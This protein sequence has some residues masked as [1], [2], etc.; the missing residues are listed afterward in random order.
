[1]PMG[2]SGAFSENMLRADELTQ[3]RSVSVLTEIMFCVHPLNSPDSGS[4]PVW[5]WSWF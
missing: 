2:T 4:S 3:F 5:C 1:M